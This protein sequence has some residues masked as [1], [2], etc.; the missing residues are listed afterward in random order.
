MSNYY[1][2]AQDLKPSPTYSD[3]VLPIDR[4]TGDMLSYSGVSVKE[5]DMEYTFSAK[6]QAVDIQN[7]GAMPKIELKDS[8]TGATYWMFWS[9]F[10]AMVFKHDFSQPISGTWRFRKQ[11]D[12]LGVELV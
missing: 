3:K 2:A 9:V 7:Y 1:K 5:F 8:T 4:R 12:G 6:L 11:G 10:K